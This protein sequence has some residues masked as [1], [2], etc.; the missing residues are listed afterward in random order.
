[1][2]NMINWFEI[3]AKDYNRAKK[4]YST[5]LS[6][7][8]KVLELPNFT[9]GLLPSDGKNVSGAIISNESYEPRDQG[10]LIYLNGRDDLN[11][12]LS[13]VEGEGGKVIMEKRQINEEFGYMALFMDTEGNRIALHSRK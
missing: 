5:I 3:P 4:F 11:K 12:M 8:I 10:V 6:V 13:K 2:E 7:E 1:M 9:M